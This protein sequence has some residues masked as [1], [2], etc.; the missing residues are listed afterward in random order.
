MKS[1]TKGQFWELVG[2]L[3]ASR[4]LQE[5]QDQLYEI[6]KEITGDEDWFW[7]VCTRRDESTKSTV[8]RLLREFGITFDSS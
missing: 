1:I 6:W 5:N 2:I 8:E 4:Q 3:A 7:D